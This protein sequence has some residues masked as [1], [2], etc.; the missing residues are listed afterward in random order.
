MATVQVTL[1]LANLPTRY[2]GEEDIPVTIE[3]AIIAAAADHFLGQFQQSILGTINLKI[4]AAI[5]EI[6]ANTINTRIKEIVE[7]TIDAQFPVY[8]K[9]GQPT[10]AMTS[11]GDKI[12]ELITKTMEEKVD[13]DG[14]VDNS[15]YGRDRAT[16]R[17]LWHVNRAIRA[18]VDG[19]LKKEIDGV[20]K[21]A[22]EEAAKRISDYLAGIGTK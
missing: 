17:W 6:I 11:L 19:T 5:D 8:S 12:T 3:E 1:D 20:V 10:S 15:S 21:K 2:N 18:E 16:P 9:Y 22:R 4:E 7:R 13:S 14:K